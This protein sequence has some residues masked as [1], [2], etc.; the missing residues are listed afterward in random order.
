MARNK[1]TE[2][3]QQV[4]ELN[5]DALA[6]ANHALTALSD[7]ARSIMSTYNLASASPDVLVTEIRGFQA[8]AVDAMFNIGVRLM[9]MRTVVQPGKWT[10]YLDQCGINDRT[11]RRVVQATI[12]FADP[13]KQRSEKLLTLGRG[14]LLELLVL[15]DDSLDVLDAGGQVGELD[16]DDVACMSPSELRN[17]LREARADAEA[18]DKVIEGK[19]TKI[20]QLEVKAARK[21]KPSADSVAKTAHEQAQ[22]DELAAATREL[23]LTFARL[24]VV[25]GDI[26]DHCGNQAVVGRALQAMQYVQKRIEETLSEQGLAAAT[27]TTGR[28]AWMDD[29]QG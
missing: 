21:F 1:N 20:D 9:L 5:H 23:E 18:K 17:A 10:H 16:L 27:S 4:V 13:T 25:V 7:Q 19:N 15:D 3:A 24:S 8:A 12:K 28:P 26:T 2:V 29:G 6:Q 11:A 14:K 22:L